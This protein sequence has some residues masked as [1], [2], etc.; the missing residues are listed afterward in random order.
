MLCR[1]WLLKEEQLAAA[2]DKIASKSR[3]KHHHAKPLLVLFH[4][5]VPRFVQGF[6]TLFK[7][8]DKYSATPSSCKSC[9]FKAMHV[10]IHRK[11]NWVGFIL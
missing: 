8:I 9:K 5:P 7:S 2:M 6:K 4:K 3:T 1:A 11:G 10:H